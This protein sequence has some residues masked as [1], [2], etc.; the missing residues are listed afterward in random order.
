[1]NE[2]ETVI[3]YFMQTNASGS[4]KA[5]KIKDVR[6]FAASAGFELSHREFRRI[7]SKLAKEKGYGSCAKGLFVCITDDDFRLAMQKL[8]KEAASIAIRKNYLI[9]IQRERQAIKD[10]KASQCEFPMQ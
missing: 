8:D 1:M 2:L 7:Y 10:G 4:S 3:D 6:A 5:K 9:K